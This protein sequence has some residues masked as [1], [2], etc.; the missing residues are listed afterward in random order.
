MNVVDIEGDIRG[1]KR[2]LAV[3]LGRNGCL[4]LQ[5]GLQGLAYL[6]A[7][8]LTI[9]ADYPVEVLSAFLVTIPLAIY[10]MNQLRKHTEITQRDRSA[11]SKLAFWASTHQ[12]TAVL[13]TYLGLCLPVLESLEFDVTSS[14]L[15]IS[16]PAVATWILTRQVVHE[17][18]SPY[19]LP[20]S[21]GQA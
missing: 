16:V 11:E 7:I 4:W 9:F 3:R 6:S 1:G 10:V 14:L 5:V 20:R 8:L 13:S 21:P 2:T 18:S 15:A 19:S 12:A 17:I